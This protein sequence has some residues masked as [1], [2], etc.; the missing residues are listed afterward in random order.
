MRRQVDPVKRPSWDDQN[1]VEQGIPPERLAATG[2]G[3]FQPLVKGKS[4]DALRKNRCIEL[5]FDQR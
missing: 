5:K 2:F 4:G 3:E 1:H